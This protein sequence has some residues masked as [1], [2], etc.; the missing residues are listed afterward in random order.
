MDYLADIWLARHQATYAGFRLRADKLKAD[1]TVDTN[2]AIG[3]R[4]VTPSTYGLLKQIIAEIGDGADEMIQ[5]NQAWLD[6]MRIN[7]DPL[8]SGRLELGASGRTSD[9]LHQATLRLSEVSPG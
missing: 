7:V 3:P 1:G 6:S 2:Q 5:D 4:T 9:I 8:N